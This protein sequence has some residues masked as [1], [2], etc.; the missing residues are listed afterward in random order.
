MGGGLSRSAGLENLNTETETSLD[1][2]PILKNF[3]QPSLC[4]YPRNLSH[5]CRLYDARVY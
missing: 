4:H 1:L 5:Y 3:L 2:V